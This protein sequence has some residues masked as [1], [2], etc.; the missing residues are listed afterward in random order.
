MTGMTQCLHSIT[1]SKALITHKIRKKLEKNKGNYMQF[2]DAT[3]I[4]S[5]N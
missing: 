4:K 5:K 3:P 1:L 2:Y